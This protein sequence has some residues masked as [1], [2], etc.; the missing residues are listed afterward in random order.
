MPEELKNDTEE[1][2]SSE[3]LNSSSSIPEFAS[4]ARRAGSKRM[5]DE[6]DKTES[7]CIEM[8]AASLF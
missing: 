3:S 6:D 5:R 2:F 7:S 4:D 1:D 8:P